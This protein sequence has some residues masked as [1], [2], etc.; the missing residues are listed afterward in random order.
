MAMCWKTG[1]VS[2]LLALAAQSSPHAFAADIASPPPTAERSQQTA[3]AVAS[4]IANY[5]SRLAA[6]LALRAKF[7]VIVAD[8]IPRALEADLKSLAGGA[9][10]PWQQT[11]LDR[12]LLSEISYFAVSLKYLI[13]SGGALWP[14]DRDESSYIN[15]ALVEVGAAVDALPE[16]IDNRENPLPLL[17]RLERIWWWTEGYGDIPPDQNH[18]GDVRARVEHALK[19]VGPQSS[20]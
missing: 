4:E 6:L 10:S 9:P 11:V 7:D 3:E 15:D 5:A 20:T 16:V 12:E 18:F 2:L 17:E 19:T 1:V 13:Q 8:D 14:T